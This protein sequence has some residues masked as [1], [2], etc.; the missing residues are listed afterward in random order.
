VT[1]RLRLGELN[2]SF[3]YRLGRLERLTHTFYAARSL[4]EGRRL[5]SYITIEAMAAWESFARS[6]FLS[7]TV[8]AQT[9]AGH[10]VSTAVQTT[11]FPDALAK[12]KALLPSSLKGAF[13]P[14][15]KEIAVVD[16]L[17]I[18]FG[19]SNVAAIQSAMAYQSDAVRD[20]NFAR[21]YFAHKTLETHGRAIGVQASYGLVGIKDLYQML[22][23]PTNSGRGLITEWLGD[24][25]V[26]GQLLCS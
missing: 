10:R 23:S 7:C 1:P 4:N 21:N 6:Y 18:S 8:G 16:S 11:S 2:R 3:E 13:G 25:Q 26:F 24:L 19:F 20:L 22:A 14:K 9:I 5:A 12:A 15:W 17:G